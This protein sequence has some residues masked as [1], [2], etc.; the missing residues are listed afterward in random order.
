MTVRGDSW[1]GTRARLL[2]LAGSTGLALVR[3]S[4]AWGKAPASARLLSGLRVRSSGAPFQGDHPALATISAAKGRST[5]RIAFTLDQP[6]RVTLD[7]L[8]TG[9]GVASE[10]PS[11]V[12]ETSLRQRTLALRAGH[13][14][15]TWTPPS[16]LP[17][18][19]YIARVTAAPARGKPQTA[20]V[21]VRLLGVDAAFGVRSVLPGQP[22]TLV[23]RSDAQT[24]NVQM[25]RSGPEAEP[26]YANNEIKGVPYGSAIGVDWH[27]HGNAPAP[28]TVATDAS[29]PSGVY[30]ARIDT[31]DGRVGFAPL[32][33]RPPAPAS[34]VAVV[35]PTS[36]WAAYNFYDAD[37]D[38]WGDT[39]YARWK[40][41]Q[42]DMTRP[43]PT[44]GV[45]YR[46]R[47]YDLAF[48]HWLNRTGKTV[49]TYADEDIELF[50]SPQALRAAYDLL[51]FPGHTEY[52]SSRLYDLVQAFRDLGGNLM[53]LS[54][55]NFFRRVDRVNGRLTLID[56]WR[57]LGR[58]ESA[59]LGNQY[60]ASDR[61][62]RR[63]P[64][65]VVG[66]DVAPWAFAGTGLQNGSTFGKYGIEIDARSPVSPTSTIVLA[67][68]PNLFG[69][70][71]TAEMTYYEHYSGARVFSA[72]TLDF[73]G[74]ALLWPETQQILANVWSRL[75]TR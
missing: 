70:G 25:L 4:T 34:R 32:I 11:A 7:I 66:A 61:G 23:V 75:T 46:Y 39:W 56:E 14:E 71:R 65:T 51:I 8:S 29:W 19:T 74:Q 41:H 44:R 40:T 45:P 62:Q 16:T 1:R 5:A 15:L 54:A 35:M 10:Q 67:N 63:G 49:D 33:V 58:P 68:I 43:Q 12:A 73:G 6:A 24:L 60:I 13:H 42:A 28:I 20:R 31:N 64:F 36:T 47:S 50:E 26:T 59:L 2:A 38:G 69:N 53:F 55:N 3:G 37:G 72:G 57:D 52:V 9:Q 18:R 27:A 22:A 17:A 21:V 48:Q 30:A